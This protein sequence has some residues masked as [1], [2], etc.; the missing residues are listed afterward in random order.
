MFGNFG[1]GF[2]S[3]N[4]TVARRFILVPCVERIFLALIVSVFDFAV[5]RNFV[6]IL[7]HL[8]DSLFKHAESF[9]FGTEFFHETS[10]FCQIGFGCV[11]VFCNFGAVNAAIL[12]LSCFSVEKFIG[13]SK[14]FCDHLRHFIPG[15]LTFAAIG[16]V[17][18]TFNDATL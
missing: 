14:S 16:A 3:E 13:T 4:E 5:P 2:K 9:K 15:D 8:V 12:I 11:I 18:V 17:A 10:E 7:P 1:F 6:V